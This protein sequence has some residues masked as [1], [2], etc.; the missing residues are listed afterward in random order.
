MATRVTETQMNQSRL[1]NRGQSHRRRRG[2]CRM[3]VA[4]GLS[5][6]NIETLMIEQTTELAEGGSGIFLWPN[7]LK[8]LAPGN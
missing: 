5:R 8:A 7:A 1:N 4:I 2:H 3:S 6:L